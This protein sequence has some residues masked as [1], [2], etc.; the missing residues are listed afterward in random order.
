MLRRY[1][2]EQRKRIS[3]GFIPICVA[4]FRYISGELWNQE[5]HLGVAL[6]V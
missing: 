1:F 4:S 3:N 5:E 6:K 2:N